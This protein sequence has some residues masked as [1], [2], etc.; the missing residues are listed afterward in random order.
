MPV[1]NGQYNQTHGNSEVHSSSPLRSLCLLIC[2]FSETIKRGYSCP[3]RRA[4]PDSHRL[5]TFNERGSLNVG[6]ILPVKPVVRFAAVTAG[7][8]GLLDWCR[9]KLLEAWGGHEELVSPPFRFD[10]TEYYTTEMGEGLWKQLLGFAELADP[11]DLPSWKLFSNQLEAQAAAEFAGDVSRPVN[12]DPGYVTEA[13][14]VLA[15]TKD[16]D[17]RIYL[18]SGIYAEVTL[19]YQR[20]AWR[21]SHWTY[22]DYQQPE[23][24]QFLSQCR[25]YLRQHLPQWR[26]EHPPSK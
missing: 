5:R 23:Y 25:D 7:S 6:S 21:A 12:I 9:H 17:H 18:H 4:C 1:H 26:A 14:L 8:T 15:T 2:V 11:A 20:K 19:Y 22:T 24:H 10:Q 16:R 13:K 3:S